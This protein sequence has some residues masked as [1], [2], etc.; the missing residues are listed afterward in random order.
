LVPT[1][2]GQQGLCGE[3]PDRKLFLRKCTKRPKE[4]TTAAAYSSNGSLTPQ[5]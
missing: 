3:V 2:A 4:K 1:A 5:T